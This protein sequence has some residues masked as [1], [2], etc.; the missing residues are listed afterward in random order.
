MRK[1]GVLATLGLSVCPVA[2]LG[3][4][5]QDPGTPPATSQPASAPADAGFRRP[6]Q[7]RGLDVLI[8]QQEVRPVL[9]TSPAPASSGVDEPALPDRGDNWSDGSLLIER[10]GRYSRSDDHARFEFVSDDGKQRSLKLLENQLLET[11]EREAEYGTQ[12]FV[13]SAEVT[14]YRG[15]NYLLLRKVLTRVSNGNLSP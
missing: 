5:S 12:E 9:P 1:W 3:S 2:I 7:A 10:P 15:E 11:M 14:L 13:I 4:Q 8:R 6:E